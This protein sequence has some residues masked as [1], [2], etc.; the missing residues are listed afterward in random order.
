MRL[1]NSYNSKIANTYIIYVPASDVSVNLATRALQSCIKL[2]Q[3]AELWPGF[4]GSGTEI[5]PPQHLVDQSWINWFRVTDH[6]LSLTEVACAL[7]H[8][9]L[10]IQC[11]NL[12]QP[13]VILEHDAVMVVPYLKHE[14]YNAV[15]YLGCNEQY[16]GKFNTN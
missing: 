10:W 6:K 2:K 5:Q 16:T 7:S 9:S 4:D 13:I 11:M 8:I 12:D 15:S 1:Y 14:I 3:P